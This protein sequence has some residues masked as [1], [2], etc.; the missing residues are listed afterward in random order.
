MLMEKKDGG[1]LSAA[2]RIHSSRRGL[3]ACRTGPVPCGKPCRCCGREE[4]VVEGEGVLSV[5]VVLGWE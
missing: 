1:V 5:G 2:E 4:V 3:R